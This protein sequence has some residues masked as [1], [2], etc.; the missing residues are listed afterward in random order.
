[1]SDPTWIG[2]DRCGCCG[3][4]LGTSGCLRCTASRTF[5]SCGALI[6]CGCGRQLAHDCPMTATNPLGHRCA[7][8]WAEDRGDKYGGKT[9]GAYRRGKRMTWIPGAVIAIWTAC[10]RGENATGAAWPHAY[11]IQTI[12]GDDGDGGSI[13]CP[14]CRAELAA[15]RAAGVVAKAPPPIAVAARPAP[16]RSGQSDLP[17]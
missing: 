9:L 5:C 14:A 8:A 16:S 6:A 17:F 15:A 12:G 1:M 7:A 10:A 11:F 3:D 13:H 4:D 2:W